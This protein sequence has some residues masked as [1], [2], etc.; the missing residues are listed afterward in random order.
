[1]LGGFLLGAFGGQ[2]AIAGMVAASVLTALI[3]TFSRSM[4]SVPR[5]ADWPRPGDEGTVRETAEVTD[6]EPACA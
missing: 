6:S 1:V 3:P 4:N 2:T 5:P